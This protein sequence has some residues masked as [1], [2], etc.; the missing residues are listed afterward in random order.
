MNTLTRSLIAAA[1]ALGVVANAFAGYAFWRTAPRVVAMMRGAAAAASDAHLAQNAA[2]LANVVA[3]PAG[4]DLPVEWDKLGPL[5][6][7]SGVVDRAKFEALYAERGGVPNDVQQ[8]LDGL[9][10]E[11]V[12]MTPTNAGAL[13][14]VL[15][16]VGLGNESDVLTKGPMATSGTDLGRFASTGGWTLAAGPTVDHI[17]K[18]RMIELT[19]DQATLVATVAHNIFRPCC[20]NPTDF[21]D[22]NH[23]MAMLGLLE[24]LASQGLSENEL[25]RTALAVNAY[26]FPDTYLSDARIAALSGKSWQSV[27]PQVLLSARFSS[28]SGTAD[29]NRVLPPLP[30][31]GGSSCAT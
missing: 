10:H 19:P 16:A 26:W 24:L 9:R 4:V 21:P 28:G 14:N 11:R 17:A 27:E 25:Y 7:T 12:R 29:V 3:P 5:L 2:W 8:I 22:C 20:N 15:W 30:S 6:V 1:V 31:S 18:H 13:L 23:G